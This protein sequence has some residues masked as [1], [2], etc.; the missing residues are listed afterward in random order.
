MTE[1]PFI[2]IQHL[3]K[4]FGDQ[5]VLNDL[6]LTFKAGEFVAIVGQSGGGKSTLLRL[7]AGL[8]EPTKGSITES[9]EQV[10]GINRQARVMFQDDR[11]LP[12]QTVLEN[13]KLGTTDK[14]DLA[15]KTLSLVG[16]A[17]FAE[18]FPDKLSGGQKQR[19]ALARALVAQPQLLLLDEPL[20]ALDALTRLNMQELIE[21]VWQKSP[22]LTM[23]LVTHDVEESVRLADRILVV[24]DHGI[25]LDLQVGLPRPRQNDQPQF[26]EIVDQILGEI[27][28]HDKFNDD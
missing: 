13:I 6:N 17:D 15:L 22:E 16:L 4:N 10:E 12:W 27:L 18:T 2:E 7:L 21:H 5:P 23:I 28:E 14:S 19:V 20:G 3:T 25:A 8:D 9:G 26:N 11:L 24:K 1:V